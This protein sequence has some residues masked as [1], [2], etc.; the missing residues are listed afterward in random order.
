MLPL[1]TAA[2][3]S[4][5]SV[6]WRLSRTKS[7]QKGTSDWDTYINR[8]GARPTQCKLASSIRR[9]LRPE[10]PPVRQSNPDRRPPRPL[11]PLPKCGI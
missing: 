4:H 5:R 9:L 2:H 11:P 8:H 10:G 7:T 3:N 1:S 6:A